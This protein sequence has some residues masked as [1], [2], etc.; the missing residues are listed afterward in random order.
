MVR[1]LALAISLLLT[2]SRVSITFGADSRDVRPRLGRVHM[3]ISCSPSV[4]RE[5]DTG[6]ALLHNFWYQ[7]ALFAFEQ[8]IRADPACA[9]AYWGA[10]MTYNHPFWDAPTQSD[11]DRAWSLV[12]SGMKAKEKSPREQLY[13]DAV[14]ALYRDGGAGGR[15]VRNNAYKNAM[16]AA[17]ARYPDDETKLF[18][19]LSIIGTIEE[20]SRWTSEQALAANLI[21]QVYAVEPHNPGALHYMIHA[22]DDPVHAA[23]GLKAA[24]AYA[25][26][27]PAVPHALHMPSHIFTRLGY[28]RESAATNEKAWRV[29]ESDVKEEGLSGA[30]RD[31]HSLN[32]LEYAY[33]Q[34]GRYRDAKRVTEIFAAEYQTLPAKI[35]AP[36]TPDLEV[37]HL[38]GRTI[39]AL[40][41][42]VVYGY[43]D[44]LARYIMETGEWQLSSALPSLPH[45]RD[46]AAMRLLVE[47]SAAAQRKDGP[48]ARAAADRIRALSSE[49]GQRPLAQEVLTI[50]AK[51][52]AAQAD[53]IGGDPNGAIAMM[54]DAVTIEDSIYALSQPPF[55]PIPAH[56]QYGTMLL[57]MNRPAHARV[58]FAECL[59]RTPGRPKSIYGLARSAQEVGDN[60]TAARQYRNFLQVWATADQNLPEIGAARRFLA[61]AHGKPTQ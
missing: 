31:F 37:R 53:L 56:E 21:E 43:F 49:P 50:E 38:R 3:D 58:Q 5:F 39:Y 1:P 32:Y 25:A 18:Y 59:K 15:S 57:K 33:L 20:G 7:P 40:P 48:A 13:L 42:R 47:A 10:A 16:A 26:A 8:V 22:Y 51:E 55:P 60:S 17:Y 27:A 30:Y 11:E 54:D 12:Q 35:T 2:V 61:S 52:A 46:F 29:S 24:R 6:I 19:A 36:D 44:T 41:D 23:Q 14:A 9:I 4:S 34:M 28:W 45:S